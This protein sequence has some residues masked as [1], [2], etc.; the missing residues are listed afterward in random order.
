MKK[1]FAIRGHET[2]GKEVIEILEMLGGKNIHNSWGVFK[3]RIYT[4]DEKTDEI[5]DVSE[6]HYSNY[7]L[8]TLEEFLEKFPYK[9]G[10][11][12]YNI[13]HN[14][15]QAITALAWDFKEN[16]VVYQTNNNE[17]VYVNYL[18]PHKEETMEENTDTALAP[19]L[20]GEDYSG[21]RFCYKIPNG[22]EFE[23][24][25]KNEIILKP[26]KQQY[27]KTYEECCRITDYHL[28]GITVIGYKAILIQDFQKLIICRDAYLKIAGE[29]IGLGKPWKQDYND[30]CFIISNNK[31]NIHTYEYHGSDNAILAFPTAEM[32]DTFYD[33]FKDLIE[34]CKEFL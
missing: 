33:N 24:V 23:C 3:N 4:I 31:G 19:D 34:Q 18:Q 16:E 13:I 11:K 17:Y 1:L 2:R 22:Y 15:N 8:F 30:R 25:N 7:N 14:E 21:R 27:P 10:D 9:V 5:I 28:K 12:V 26:I 29:H 32:R 6:R 20:K